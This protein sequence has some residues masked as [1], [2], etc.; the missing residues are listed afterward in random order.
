M[1]TSLITSSL[2]ILL[3]ITAIRMIKFDY[4][5]KSK[6]TVALLLVFSFQ[7]VVNMMA[8]IMTWR[9]MASWGLVAL[10]SIIVCINT[11]VSIKEYIALHNAEEDEYDNDD[12][13]DEEVEETSENEG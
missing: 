7:C 3:L 6:L 5:R 2:V 1:G 8:N 12:V 13:Y 9:I 11:V 4:L 10:A